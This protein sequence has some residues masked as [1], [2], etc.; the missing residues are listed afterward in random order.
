MSLMEVWMVHEV[1][2]S[3]QTACE[4]CLLPGGEAPGE[5]RDSEPLN[6]ARVTG[7]FH[8]EVSTGTS[9]QPDDGM[10]GRGPGQ[11]DIPQDLNSNPHQVLFAIY[12]RNSRAE[13]FTTSFRGQ[14][15][16]GFLKET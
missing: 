12:L 10:M 14:P 3:G 15:A 5:R 7:G 2:S 13:H 9:T 4:G 16:R 6:A 8:P 11:L 1:L